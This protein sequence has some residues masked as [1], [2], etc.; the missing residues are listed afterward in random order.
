MKRPR[1]GNAGAEEGQSWCRKGGKCTGEVRVEVV[2]KEAVRYN[3]IALGIVENRGVPDTG[4][5]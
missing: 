4:P 5:P 3:P 2:C 1:A